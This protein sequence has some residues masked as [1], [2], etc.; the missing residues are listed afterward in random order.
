MYYLYLLECED[1]SIYTG[2]TTDIERRFSEHKTGIG[3]RFTRSRKVKRILHTEEF[4]TRSQALKREVE[5]KSWPRSKKLI[6]VT[7]KK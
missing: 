3:S 4:E 7:P 6:L 2:I 5:I 1:G